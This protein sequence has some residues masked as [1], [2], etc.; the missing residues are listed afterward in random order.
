MTATPPRV[1]VV[2]VVRR[3]QGLGEHI[4]RWLLAA[5]AEVPAFIGSRV[6]TLD[7]GR[8]VLAG[9]GV[10]AR[11]YTSLAALLRAQPLD[12]LVI[13]SPP[14]THDQY[15]T[16]A[17]EA[18]LAV[19]C[20]KPFVWGTGD[21]V[22]R[23]EH[24]LAAFAAAGLPLWEC[25]QWPLTLPSYRHLHPTVADAPVRHVEMWLSPTSGGAAMIAD[26]LSHPLSLVQ[27]LTTPSGPIEGLCFSTVAQDAGRLEALF[28]VSTVEGGAVLRVRLARKRE[29]PRPAGYALNGMAAERRVR[30]EDY[31]LSFEHDGR[32][33]P[34]PDPLAGLVAG[35]VA[36]VRDGAAGP[37]FVR[38]D[39]ITWRMQAL[40]DV[41]TGFARSG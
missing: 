12:A 23:T 29:Q 35:F 8:A 5:G 27:A 32:T 14:A 17:C 26:S 28:R 38:G 11:G 1:G 20:E 21:D 39:A 10:E 41:V 22:A 36:A 3:R 6:E 30:M 18:G 33:V 37:D 24:H 40:V 34:I 7:E 15:L 9:H 4:A 13:A 31:A 25:V 16:E 19:L 2:G